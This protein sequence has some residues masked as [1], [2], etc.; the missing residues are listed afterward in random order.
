MP[1]LTAPPSLSYS[2]VTI[3]LQLKLLPALVCARKY[4]TRFLFKYHSIFKSNPDASVFCALALFLF[5]VFC[6]LCV[7]PF[8]FCVACT[9]HLPLST[10]HSGALLLIFILFTLTSFSTLRCFLE[11]FS[12]ARALSYR[13]ASLG[14]LQDLLSC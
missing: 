9:L 4:A 11:H 1:A 13:A 14:H 5:A 7:P 6:F 3:K 2:T 8:F 12:R 10:L